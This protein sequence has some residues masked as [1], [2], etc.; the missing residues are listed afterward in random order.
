[1]RRKIYVAVVI[2]GVAVLALKLQSFVSAKKTKDKETQAV[3]KKETEYNPVVEIENT[4]AQ[5]DSILEQNLKQSGTVGAAAVVTYK[6]KVALVKCFGVR[7]AGEKAPVNA[8]TVFRLASVSKSVTG[9]LAGILDDENIIKLDDKVVD[10]IPGF[11]LK[12]KEC[13]D[14]LKVRH[15][16]SHTSGL[17]PH[18]Y[19]LMVED[20]VPLEKI[21]ERLNQV[22]ITAPPGEL[23][24][25]QNVVYSIYDP[26]TKAKTQKSFESVMKEKVFSPF[27]MTDASMN[28]EA[29]KN[30]KNK[31]F[32][33]YNQGHNRYKPM[34]LNDRYYSTAPAAGV[35][36][37]INDMANFL[38]TLTDDNSEVFNAS[39]RQT[40][41]TPQVNS[42]LKRTYFRSWGREVKSKRYSLGWRIID[43]KGREVAYH[44]G[45]VLGYKAEIALCD[46]EDI[47]IA[48]LSNSPN[49]ATAKNIPTFLSLLFD[50]KDSVALKEKKDNAAS[51]NKS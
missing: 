44:G 24:G 19:D 9:V 47:G 28:F 15:L 41:F 49:S 13:T 51:E 35:N 33:H 50:Y 46:E 37:S 43:Y 25:Y 29:F 12:D 26:I 6:G 27:G 36:A 23:Y 20:K 48:I 38:A 42:P 39:A 18:A 40:V 45:Y 7:K 8:N 1:M 21:I 17:I 22:D 14:Q 3:T 30:N 11:E 4:L 10:Y 34:R 32:P 31:A 16:L 5:F 2:V